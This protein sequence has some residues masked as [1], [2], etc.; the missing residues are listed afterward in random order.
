MKLHY[1][2]VALD[3]FE[4]KYGK[5]T[6]VRVPLGCQDGLP[7]AALFTL[8]CRELVA[9]LNLAIARVTAHS[10]YADVEFETMLPALERVFLP[11]YVS[12][13]FAWIEREEPPTL[14][15]I[16]PCGITR[17]DCEYHR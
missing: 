13:D 8:T 10:G 2:T 16:C 5:L 14:K 12:L 7:I 3:G 4:V 6:T 9:D 11:G 1:A 17:T 15:S